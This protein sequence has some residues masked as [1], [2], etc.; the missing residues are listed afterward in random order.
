[1][2]HSHPPTSPDGRTGA[3]DAEPLTRSPAPGPIGGGIRVWSEI[4][5]GAGNGAA[6]TST[7]RS[8]AASTITATELEEMLTMLTEKTIL[9]CYD[10]SDGSHRAIATA[11]ELFAD[12]KAIVLHVWSPVSVM[13]AAYG[14][15]VVLPTY[16][17]D[18][19]QEA[20]SKVA[21]A[22]CRLATQAG[23]KAR[24]EVAEVT[25]QGAWHTILEVADQHD[26][27]LVVLGARGLSAFKSIVLGSVSHSVAQHSHIPVLIVPPADRAKVVSEPAEHAAV[28]A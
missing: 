20:A 24:P 21:E 25:Y 15:M 22:G 14:G 11:G 9:I 16:D 18:A 27:E 19:L 3:Y 7:Q 4:D 28:T 26:A 8:R 2:R 17:D 6:S 1:L 5:R 12:R 10:N 13:V 23:L